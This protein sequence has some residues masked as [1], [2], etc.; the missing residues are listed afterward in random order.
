MLK[1]IFALCLA[2]L[3]LMIPLVGCKNDSDGEESSST[4]SVSTSG[5]EGETYFIDTLPIDKYKQFEELNFATIVGNIV[6]ETLTDG[7]DMIESKK[8]DRDVYVKEKL[9][10]KINYIESL[11]ATNAEEVAQ[12]QTWALSGLNDIDIFGQQ[13]DN[14]MSLALNDCLNDLRTISTINLDNPWWSQ[15]ANANLSF[16]GK[17]YVAIGP[18]F[19]WYYGAVLAMAYNKGM[20]Q[21]L[22]MEDLY[23]VVKRGD[24][25]LETLK[26]MCANY[27]LTDTEQGKYAFSCSSGVGPYGIFASAGGKF[28]TFDEQGNI[29]V[30]VAGEDGERVLSKL[31]EAFKI[32]ETVFG[33]ITVSSNAFINKQTMFWNTTIGYIEQF[34]PSSDV[35]YGIIPCPKYDTNQENYI[36]CAWPSSSTSVAI[37]KGIAGERLEW[38]AM[39]LDAYAFLGDEMVKPAKYD[40]VLKYHVALDEDAST[41]LDLI[42]EDVY[43]DLNL[44]CDLGGSRT[45]VATAI[46]QKGTTGYTSGYTLISP[47]VKG[48]IN[49]YNALVG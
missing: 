1:R 40:A 48:A 11:S 25:T 39:F 12:M 20:A 21:Q 27:G 34:L 3:F 37:P 17:Q 35:D 49:K 38:V 31:L 24:W 5:G 42:F 6:P 32:N 23:A 30:D 10:I 45:Y 14:L 47:I 7:G 44:I 33:N 19:E 2:L 13:P 36:S 28:S 4:T 26:N 16:G 29:V 46:T 43:Y 22:G 8:F 15:N 41:M 18:T 9:G